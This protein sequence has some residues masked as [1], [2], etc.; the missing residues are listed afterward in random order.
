MEALLTRCGVPP[1]H[2]RPLAV[3]GGT[4]LGVTPQPPRVPADRPMIYIAGG[5]LRDT[6]DTGPPIMLLVGDATVVRMDTV[7][8]G[9]SFR[10]EA[11]RLLPGGG[12]WHVVPLPRPPVMPLLSPFH[13]VS[14]S[15]YFV[16]D[17]RVWISVTGEGIFSLNAEE[18][19]WRMEFPEEIELLEGRALY[20]PEL[21]SVVGLTPGDQLLYAYGFD[22][23]GVPRWR[24]T[25]REA[26]PWECYYDGK[27]PSREMV[28]LA[29]LGKRRFCIFRPVSRVGDQGRVTCNYNSFLVLELRRRPADGD[30]ELAKR[31]TLVYHGEWRPGNCLGCYFID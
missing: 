1:L 10:F 26:I 17:A 16:K 2:Y 18:G 22:E 25:W 24:R 9:E 8:Y 15:S 13:R 31:G 11:L 21:G 27:T 4:I 29:Y 12:G 28:S 7:I 14:I 6:A 30:L 3:S 19:S 23:R 20:V 5:E